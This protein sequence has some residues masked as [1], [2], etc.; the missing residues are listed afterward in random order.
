MSTKSDCRCLACWWLPGSI[1]LNRNHQQKCLKQVTQQ[2]AQVP[3]SWFKISNSNCIKQWY[4]DQKLK[5][6][7]MFNSNERQ[8]QAQHA[9]SI[10]EEVIAANSSIAHKPRGMARKNSIQFLHF[11]SR[12]EKISFAMA[13]SSKCCWLCEGSEFASEARF[14]PFVVGW[15]RRLSAII[16]R[17]ATSLPRQGWM[18]SNSTEWLSWSDWGEK[19]KS[20]SSSK[21]KIPA[22]GVSRSRSCHYSSAKWDILIFGSFAH[23]S[24]L[25]GKRGGLMALNLLRNHFSKYAHEC[26]E[27][28]IV[29]NVQ[30]NSELRSIP[31]KDGKCCFA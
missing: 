25:W 13:G 2:V 30:I 14:A 24:I 1:A 27:K 6:R 9:N 18:D 8:R 29:I 4:R 10:N 7:P 26:V 5:I 20:K 17:S 23:G 3:R 21:S 15:M 22:L 16:K 31:N 19:S 28:D 12:W 11:A